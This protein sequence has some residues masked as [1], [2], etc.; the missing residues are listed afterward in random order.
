MKDKI[1]S[2]SD[3]HLGSLVSQLDK[4]E[5]VLKEENYETL[6]LNGDIIDV[7]HPQRLSKKDWHFITLLSKISK[8]KDCYWN[9]GNHDSDISKM[10]SELIGFK[11]GR[12]YTTKINK[13]TILITHGDQ[14]DSFIGDHPLITNIGSGI[15][16]W[17]QAIDPKN[18]K[19]CRFLKHRS[20]SFIS[21]T[22]RVRKNAVAFAK[23]RAVDTIICGHT[24]RAES[25]E[26]NGVRYINSGSFTDSECGY[27]TIDYLGKITLNRL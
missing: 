15:Y 18:Q 17:L 14:F 24:H 12:E 7:N 8:H 9:G 11:H 20:K 16:Y 19:L 5:Y 27:V 1:L 22:E 23:L 25:S 4:A 2:L 26:L 6:V 10:L 3:I 21:A 13:N